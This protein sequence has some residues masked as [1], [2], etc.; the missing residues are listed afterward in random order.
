MAW[1]AERIEQVKVLAEQ[2][3]SASEIALEI[4]DVT[5][6]AVVG[7]VFRRDDIK[8]KGGKDGAYTREKRPQQ[9]TPRY[10]LVDVEPLFVATPV[11]LNELEPHHCKWPIGDPSQPDFRFCGGLKFN[12]Y[13]YCVNHARIAYQPPEVSHAHPHREAGNGGGIDYAVRHRRTV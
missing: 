13:P 1:T 6:N 8:L 5:R 3:L 11:T 9:P 12:G 7:L 10:M 2:G 4:G